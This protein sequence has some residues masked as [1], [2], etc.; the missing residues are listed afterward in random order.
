M[1]HRVSRSRAIRFRPVQMLALWTLV[2]IPASGLQTQPLKTTPAI[3]FDRVLDDAAE[4]P[5]LHSLLISWKGDLLVEQ[6]F[7]NSRPTGL[8]NL[9]SAS[10]SVMSALV[11]IA[12]ERGILENVR[13]PI[14]G[15]FPDLLAGEAN[16]PKR[17][18][19]IEDLLTM[20][21]GL[22]TTSNRNYGAW[23]LSSNWVRHALNQPL[24][25]TPGTRMDYSTG[26]THLLSAIL[27]RVTGTSTWQF[28]RDFLAE[29][30]GFSLAEWPRDPQGVY[31]GGNDMTMTPRQM[32]IF[33]QMYLNGGRANGRQVVPEQ[34]V[35]AS[36][37]ARTPSPRE[38]GR[39]YGYGWWIRQMAGHATFYA[40]GYGGQFIFLVP[41]LELVV[42]TTSSSNPGEGRRRHL[43]EI[44][45]FVE[46][47]IVNPITLLDT[48]RATVQESD[49]IDPQRTARL[50]LR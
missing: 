47:H 25:R 13:Q 28:A 39:F 9:K 3:S 41:D 16:T 10:K 11:G 38:R 18:I 42:V 31:F 35:E 50:A 6:Y 7:N 34:W 21:S 40:W 17:A 22:E 44:Y 27:T 30:M 33:G 20:R 1:E 36:F 15:F 19:T 23:V 49:R 4:L 2:A 24:I 46:D 8:A 29:P 14:G 45:R 37:V 26:N 5:R 32:M 12:L 43:R 48:D